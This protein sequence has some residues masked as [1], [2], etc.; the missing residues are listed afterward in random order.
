M[1]AS[2]VGN[3]MAD[4]GRFMADERKRLAEVISRRNIPLMD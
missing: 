3:S 2:P 1:G 4:F